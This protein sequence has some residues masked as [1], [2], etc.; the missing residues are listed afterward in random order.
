MRA[1][2]SAKVWR[3]AFAILVRWTL[4]LTILS[5]LVILGN[6]CTQSLKWAELSIRDHLGLSM[7]LGGIRFPPGSIVNAS[8]PFF[9]DPGPVYVRSQGE[10]RC[11]GTLVGMDSWWEFNLEGNSATLSRIWTTSGTTPRVLYSKRQFPNL[12]PAQ[13]ADSKVIQGPCQLLEP[14][15]ES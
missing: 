10:H 3:H 1:M 5:P 12:R 14:T 2:K 8:D 9:L 4:I 15:T 6:L 13:N 7:C 11:D